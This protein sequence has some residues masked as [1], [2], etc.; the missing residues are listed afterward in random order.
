[1]DEC[2]W[3][4]KSVRVVEQVGEDLWAK[5]TAWWPSIHTV[6]KLRLS[7]MKNAGVP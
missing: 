6:A 3:R 7:R 5:W 2:R 1:M 4:D